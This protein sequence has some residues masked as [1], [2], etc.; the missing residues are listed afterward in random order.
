MVD[1]SGT[2]QH[3]T[4]PLTALFEACRNLLSRAHKTGRR[5]KDRHA[6]P[7]GTDAEIR[8]WVGRS[9]PAHMRKDLGLDPNFL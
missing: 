3:A 6:P 2:H 9:V 7:H 5:R 1:I 4:A 8:R